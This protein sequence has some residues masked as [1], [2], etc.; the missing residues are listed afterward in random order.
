VDTRHLGYNP[1]RVSSLSIFVDESGNFDFSGGGS[2]YFHL[3]AVSTLGCP[4]LLADIFDLKHR[5]AET[6]LE[7]E[8]FHATEDRQL[9]RDQMFELIHRHSEHRCF[10]VDAIT[11]RKSRVD[12]ALQEPSVLYATMLRSLLRKVFHDHASDA[13]DGILVWAARIGTK[14]QR[15]AFEKTVKMYLANELEAAI[16]YHVFL[17]SSSSHPM[18]QVADYCCWA[19]AKKWKD[20][21]LRPFAK[22]QRAMGA[23]VEIFYPEI[24]GP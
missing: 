6:G 17:H 3:T 9:V 24:A 16:P 7:I 10:V 19:V 11:V 15:G 21:E 13:V 4:A 12:P 20:G 18:L 1:P 8:E 22:I 2:K 5:I 23:E 14:K